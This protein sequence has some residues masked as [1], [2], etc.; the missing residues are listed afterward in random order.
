MLLKVGEPGQHIITPERKLY[1]TATALPS[2]SSDLTESER[3]G[4]CHWRRHRTNNP[5]SQPNSHYLRLVFGGS[6]P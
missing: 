5:R 6:Q 4:S 1:V 2:V 3:P